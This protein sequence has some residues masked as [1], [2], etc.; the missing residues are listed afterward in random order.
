LRALFSELKKEHYK[1]V[2]FTIV[3]PNDTYVET[4]RV[5]IGD[6]EKQSLQDQFEIIEDG[7]PSIPGFDYE[8]MEAKSPIEE[9][10]DWL[11]GTVRD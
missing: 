11:T 2:S 4:D 1:L 8:E 9:G 6:L 3:F 10:L 5:N 7:D